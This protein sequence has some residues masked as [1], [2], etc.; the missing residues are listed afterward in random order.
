VKFASWMIERAH[1]DLPSVRK[2]VRRV[3]E[4]RRTGWR[5]AKNKRGYSPIP[6]KL[7]PYTATANTK[8]QYGRKITLCPSSL[9][10]AEESNR[11]HDRDRSLIAAREECL[12]D[13]PG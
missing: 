10:R 4:G 6:M 7:Q 8:K 11:L 12:E 9:L 13:K 3:H 1:L 2:E 5:L